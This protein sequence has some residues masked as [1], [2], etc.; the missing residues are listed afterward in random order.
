MKVEE[1]VD[2]ELGTNY[3]KIEVGEM[4]QVALLCTQY[5]PAHRPKMSE[6]VLMLEGDGLAERWAASHNHSHFYHANISFMTNSSLSTT[7]H[8]ND[9]T[10]Q[11]FGSSA[12]DDDDDQQP[13]DLLAMELSG[14]R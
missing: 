7:S 3:D 9:P 6:V 1:L 4:L 11:M 12:F 2:R 14:P 8:C 13:L 10:Y 5:L